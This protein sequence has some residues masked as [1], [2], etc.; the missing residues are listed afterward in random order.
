[1][2]PAAKAV[3]QILKNHG[4]TTSINDCLKVRDIVTRRLQDASCKMGNDSECCI[5]DVILAW[6]QNYLPA[7][8]ADENWKLVLSAELTAEKAVCVAHQKIKDLVTKAKQNG[9]RVIY[10]SD[11][12]LGPREIISLLDSVGSKDLFD[13]GYV[14]ADIG[15]N[16][17]S[18]RL[19]EYVIAK[20]NLQPA[21]LLHVG[22]NYFSDVQVPRK[23]GINAIHFQDPDFE[24]WAI[25]HRKLKKMNNISPKWIGARWVEMTPPN[26]SFLQR[27]KSDAGYGIGYFIL[28]P[29]LVNFIHQVIKNFKKDKPELAL[30]TAR[31][32]FVLKEIYERLKAKLEYSYLPSS[33][34]IFLSRQ[35]TFLAS[36]KEIGER[37]IVRG[38]ETRPTLRKLLNKLSLEPTGLETVAKKCGFADLDQLI[39]EPL[40]D[41]ALKRFLSHPE[42]KRIHRAERNSHLELLSDYL[43][44]F[45]FWELDIAAIVDVGWTGTIQESLALAFSDRPDW[46]FL[47]GYYMALLNRSKAPR[48]VTNK[49]R[50][51][52]IF[53][54]YQTTNNRTGIGRFTELFEN[55]TRA[56]HGTTLGYRRKPNDH[57]APILS[58]SSS[59]SFNAE[60]LDRQLVASLQAGIFDYTENY[61]NSIQF[62]AR[63]PQTHQDFVV[64]L[65]DRLVRF[66]SKKEALTLKKLVYLNDFGGLLFMPG[67]NPGNPQSECFSSQNA[68]PDNRY[69]VMWPEGYYANKGIPGLTSLFNIYRTIFKQTF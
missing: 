54:D 30:F 58:T 39:K 46:P 62:Q 47:N 69:Y 23:L 38:L 17:K 36:A 10:I 42:F 65:V 49:S 59:A 33:K 9:T 6:L 22:D 4:I 21:Q 27:A 40:K 43:Q 48:C 8:V 41:E 11:M 57:V 7:D 37:E 68:T 25:R 66:P 15:L 45:K 44:Q 34:Y 26:S 1:M 13:A 2:V 51:N 64:S 32:G 52:G 61:T 14:S 63:P 12:Y 19:F 31:E 20:E 24:N 28:G 5:R 16:K 67:L 3:T 18:G 50:F 53:Y 29:V 60:Q 35:S 56:P 55:A